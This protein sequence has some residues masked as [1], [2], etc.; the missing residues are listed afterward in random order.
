[1]SESPD[2]AAQVWVDRIE[3]RVRSMTERS[4]RRAVLPE[5]LVELSAED[6]VEALALLN[7]RARNGQGPARSVLQELALDQDVFDVLAYDVRQRAYSMARRGELDVVARMLL[8]DRPN[9]NPTVAEAATDNEYASES[10][11]E[12]CSHARG[13]DRN[14]L[15]RLLHDRDLRVIA[16]LLNNP[17]LIERDVIKIAA[18]RPTR[19]EVLME[20]A[21]HRRWASRYD[22]RKA[23]TCNPHTP[24]NVSLRLLPTLMRQDIRAVLDTGS[25]PGEVREQAAE[26][27]GKS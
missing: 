20:V 6:L 5:L 19:A 16:I 27:L 21:R 22:V 15:D 25:I 3:R 10:V 18:M 8:P 11:G 23:L 24:L 4:M 7:E 2:S 12:R 1:M 14:K 17:I 13:R 26:L 9:S